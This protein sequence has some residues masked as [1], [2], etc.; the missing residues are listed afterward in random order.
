MQQQKKDP[1]SLPFIEEVLIIAAR[2]ETY[3]FLDGYSRYHHIWI[4]PKDRYKTS[5]V[6]D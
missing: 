6:T 5:F 1:F 2:C 4:V 3:S